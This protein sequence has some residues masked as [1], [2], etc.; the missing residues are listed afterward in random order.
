MI[1]LLQEHLIY[2]ERHRYDV[3]KDGVMKTREERDVIGSEAPN[4]REI[5]DKINEIINYINEKAN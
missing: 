5:M 3:V 2:G 4:N 1:E